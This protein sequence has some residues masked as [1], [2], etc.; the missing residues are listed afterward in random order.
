MKFL[1]YTIVIAFIISCGKNAFLDKEDKKNKRVVMTPPAQ[2][3]Y[4]DQLGKVELLP[5]Y[6]LTDQHT[7]IPFYFHEK[8][9]N[10]HSYT[11]VLN[12][13]ERKILFNTQV[14]LPFS[15]DSLNN[16]DG[17]IVKMD[18]VYQG[19]RLYDTMWHH[20][21]QF[22]QSN[23]KTCSGNL[24]SVDDHLNPHSEYTWENYDY[25]TFIEGIESTDVSEGYREQD[26]NV[27]W[28][29]LQYFYEPEFGSFPSNYLITIADHQLI[30]EAKI[31][32]K[33]CKN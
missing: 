32:V 25:G 14:L 6:S 12:G 21:P 4:C 5:D 1:K 31:I 7:D 2:G 26:L 17:E 24:S 10:E 20:E 22:C 29:L 9:I 3:E 18:L 13:V 33:Y 28:D 11:V 15:F 8:R 19:E 27:T 16:I 30:K 23:G